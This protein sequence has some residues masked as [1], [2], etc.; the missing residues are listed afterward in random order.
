M[1][2]F[3]SRARVGPKS[4]DPCPRPPPWPRGQLTLSGRKEQ[5][6]N[7][8]QDTHFSESLG[9]RS[10]AWVQVLNLPLTH[11]VTFHH[12]LPHVWTSGS[13]SGS[14][15]VGPAELKPSPV[16]TVL[17]KSGLVI[18]CPPLPA[19]PVPLTLPDTVATFT[20]GQTHIHIQH[21]ASASS[22]LQ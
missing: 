18:L 7:T 6:E 11:S 19:P 4:R 22:K 1:K 14:Q 15:G 13:S 12:S 9:W 17:M 20:K 3:F 16:D 8:W 21:T 2:K 5:R 10:G